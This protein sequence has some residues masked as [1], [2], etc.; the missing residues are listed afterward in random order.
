MSNLT[1][2]NNINYAQRVIE[3]HAE[4]SSLNHHV[5]TIQTSRPVIKKTTKKTLNKKKRNALSNVEPNLLGMKKARSNNDD[6]T[7][8][9][10]EDNF[11]NIVTNCPDIDELF[12][13]GKVLRENDIV[14]I[15]GKAGLGKTQICH[16]FAANCLFNDSKVKLFGYHVIV[17]VFD[18]LV[19]KKFYN[20]KIYQ[21]QKFQN[22]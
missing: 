22:Y 20:Q 11:T 3:S 8:N 1:T 2:L 10:D 16:I 5:E 18:H 7:T 17:I 4:T 6:N 13:E 19:S 15:Y 14:S 21:I 12:H 9:T